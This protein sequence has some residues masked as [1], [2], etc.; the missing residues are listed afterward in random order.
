[1]LFSFE[2]SPAP[3]WGQN[4]FCLLIWQYKHQKM[5]IENVS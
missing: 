3:F 4:I 1:M 2:D 5:R